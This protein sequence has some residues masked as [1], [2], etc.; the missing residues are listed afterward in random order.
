MADKFLTVKE[1]LAKG[2]GTVQLRG[3]AH[4]VRTFN[5]K[6][7]VVL[8]DQTG[9]LQCVIKPE[10]VS[11]KIFQESRKLSQESS[12]TITGELKKDE[13]APGGAEL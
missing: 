12:F 1:A 2:K 7:F 13:R 4:R 5:D 9:L 6:V 3:W 10:Q 8:R 11:D